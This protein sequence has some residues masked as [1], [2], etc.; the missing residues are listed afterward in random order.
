MP[1]MKTTVTIISTESVTNDFPFFRKNSG[2]ILGHNSKSNRFTTVLA[3]IQWGL[4]RQ[5]G[6]LNRF[7][8]NR[9]Y[10]FIGVIFFPESKFRILFGLSIYCYC[11]WVWV[12]CWFGLYCYIGGLGSIKVWKV[13]TGFRFMT[14]W[15]IWKIFNHTQIMEKHIF[16]YNH[17]HSSMGNKQIHTY[18]RITYI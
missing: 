1:V 14:G 3:N 15:H 8:S 2:S 17:T 12:A 5:Y 18:Q 9:R 11:V 13:R 10:V 16:L 6:T 4:R 7:S